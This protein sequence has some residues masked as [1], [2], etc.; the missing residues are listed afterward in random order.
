M[1]QEAR[2]S[3]ITKKLRSGDGSLFSGGE[4]GGTRMAEVSRRR[5]SV[6]PAATQGSQPMTSNLHVFSLF[7]CP[8]AFMYKTMN[9]ILE[10]VLRSLMIY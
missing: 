6:T 4:G 1:S 9:M 5:A 7:L 10:G 8:A 2:K 3:V